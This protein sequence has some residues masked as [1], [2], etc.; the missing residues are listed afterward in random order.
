M[1]CFGLSY[2]NGGGGARGLNIEFFGRGN[3]CFE[4]GKN[5]KI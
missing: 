4:P 3:L 1:P 5:L 2:I